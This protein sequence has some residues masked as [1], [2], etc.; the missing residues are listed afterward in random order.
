MLSQEICKEYLDNFDFE[1]FNIKNKKQIK[2]VQINNT[3][4]A[5][6]VLESKNKIIEGNFIITFGIKNNLIYT[7][8][9]FNNNGKRKFTESTQKFI[10]KEK[11][12]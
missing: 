7:C 2:F 8:E 6:L 10:K 12:V 5:N 4:K 1:Q 9:F 3:Y 11:L